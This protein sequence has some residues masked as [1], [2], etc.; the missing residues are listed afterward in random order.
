MSARTLPMLLAYAV[1]LAFAL[2]LP[3]LAH[4]QS[5]TVDLGT[6]GEA[7][8]TSRLVQITALITVLSL[9][10]AFSSWGRPSPES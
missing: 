10:R 7:G 4:A 9:A 5:V 6:A 3:V 8:A 2:L 1:L